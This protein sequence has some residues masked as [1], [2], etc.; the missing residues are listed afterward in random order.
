MITEYSTPVGF[1]ETLPGTPVAIA[2]LA[3]RIDH[4]LGAV[5]TFPPRTAPAIKNRN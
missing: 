5:R 4:A 2:M 3:A 1:A